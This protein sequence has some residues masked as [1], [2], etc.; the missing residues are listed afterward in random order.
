MA[1]AG[2]TTSRSSSTSG[3]SS[4][5]G[6]TIAKDALRVVAGAVALGYAGREILKARKPRVMGVPLPRKLGHVGV[7]DIAKQVSKVAAQVERASE[8]VRMASSQTKRVAKKLS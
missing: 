3:Q 6:A 5:G 8:D 7:K 1:A 2:K 4:N